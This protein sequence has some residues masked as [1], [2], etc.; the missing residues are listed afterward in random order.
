MNGKFA[1]E[2]VRLVN[3]FTKEFIGDFCDETGA[4]LWDKLVEFNSGNLTEDDKTD[5]QPA[6][7]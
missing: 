3:K 6:G 1:E 2:K 5:L 7:R 4:I